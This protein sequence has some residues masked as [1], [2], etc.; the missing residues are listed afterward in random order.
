MATQ[1]LYAGVGT[2]GTLL[3]TT[4]EMRAGWKLCNTCQ[5][6]GRDPD[7]GPRKRWDWPNDDYGDSCP[8]CRGHGEVEINDGSDVQ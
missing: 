4:V 1:R 5:G 6:S 7:A 2:D 3:Y 8:D